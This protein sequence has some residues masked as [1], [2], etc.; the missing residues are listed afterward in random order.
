MGKKIIGVETRANFSDIVD[1]IVGE[2]QNKKI[3]SKC[4]I[5]T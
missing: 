2:S 1:E 3:M 5:I 4:E